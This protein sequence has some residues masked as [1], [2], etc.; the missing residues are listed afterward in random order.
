MARRGSNSF[1]R[2]DG[3]RALRI[4]RDGGM[5]PGMMEITVATDG[6]VTFRVYGEKAAGLMVLAPETEADAREWQDEIAK[7]KAKMPKPKGR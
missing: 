5:E 7:L 4:A 2:N 6:A 3:I 1:R